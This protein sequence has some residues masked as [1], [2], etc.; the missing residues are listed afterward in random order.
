MNMYGYVFGDDTAGGGREKDS[1]RERERSCNTYICISFIYMYIYVYKHVCIFVY[2][3]CIQ[4]VHTHKPIVHS[5]KQRC[6]YKR[7]CF[8]MDSKLCMHSDP[9]QKYKC[10]CTYTYIY[11]YICIP[12]GVVYTYIY[13]YN[14]L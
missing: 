14:A 3:I 5:S 8:I 7:R 11:I 1:E 13:M 4:S 6:I 9:K 10:I 2:N 12:N